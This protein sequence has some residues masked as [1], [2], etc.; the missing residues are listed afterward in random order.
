MTELT[1]TQNRL[2]YPLLGMLISAAAVFVPHWVK[3]F[4]AHFYLD[5]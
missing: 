4:D 5:D 3:T 1:R 2:F